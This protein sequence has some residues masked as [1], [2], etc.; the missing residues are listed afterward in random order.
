[1]RWSVAPG[2]RAG[3]PFLL[4]LHG[5]NG[6]EHQLAV[7]AELLPPE[8]VIV[9]P[10][11]PFLESGGWSWFELAERGRDDAAAIADELFDWLDR[12][13]GY[14]SYGVLGLS[15]GAAMAMELMRLRPRRFDYVIQLSGFAIDTSPDAE[16][17]LVRPPMFSAHGD[18]DTVIPQE[19]VLDTGRWL[20]AH[21]TLTEKRYP[22]LG[23][24]VTEEEILDAG[25]F[26][27]YRLTADTLPR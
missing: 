8:L 1:M 5:H 13:E 16:L 18:L 7:S 11:A 2:E 19:R 24:E 23:H 6:D 17:A 20:A 9:T 4:A 10:R 27:R 26:I 14:S 25:E 12:Q 15:Q 22:N 3:R 21:T